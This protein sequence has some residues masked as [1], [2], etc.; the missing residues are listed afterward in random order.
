MNKVCIVGSINIDMVTTTPRI[1]MLGETI[2]G[3]GFATVPGG[4]GANQ[5]VAAARLGADVTMVGCVG[6]DAFGREML[7]NFAA[8]GICTD[9]I[10]TVPE[11]E[12]GTATILVCGGDNLIILNKGANA[13]VSPQM[14]GE[15]GDVLRGSDVIM[16]QN[17]IP[18]ETNRAVFEGEHGLI[19]YNPAPSASVI[20]DYLYKT[21][22]LVVNEHECGDITG[23]KID[24]V[25]TARSAA[26]KLLSDGIKNVIITLGGD[27]AVYTDNGEV[28]SHSAIRVENVADTTAAGDCFCGAV[29]KCLACGENIHNAIAYATAA[30]AITVT[31]KGAQ[32]SIPTHAQVEQFRKNLG[33]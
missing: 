27:G 14:I 23:I 4:K 12:T 22:I 24:S 33:V 31:K 26:K 2:H 17:E 25:D 19:L 10:K 18:S 16:L 8:D 6:G 29:A 7:K 5:A 1:P 13:Y 30:S 32:S 9:Y 28:Y 11:T 21:D 20:P 15:C 3:E